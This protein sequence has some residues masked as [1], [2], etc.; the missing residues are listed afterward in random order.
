ML[1][2]NAADNLTPQTIRPTRSI[3]WHL[4]VL[5]AASIVPA[6]VVSTLL[7]HGDYRR[8]EERIYREGIL[9]ARNLASTLDR[10]LTGVES[11]LK[12]LATS[13]DLA[14]DDLASFHRRARDALRFQIVDNYFMTDREGRQYINTL[15]PYGTSLPQSGAPAQ[16]RRVFDTRE[17]V[18]TDIFL[19]KVSHRPTIAMGVPV[20]R[21]G[22][23]A[24]S[25][26]I[27]LS[28]DRIAAIA[29]V[30]NVPNGWIAAILDSSGNIV[31]RSR[32]GSRYIGQPAVQ[33]LVEAISRNRE[34]TLDTISKEGV[35]LFTAFS[36]SAISTW[37]VA[38][39]APQAILN[40]ELYR[41]L[42]WAILG[43]ICAVGIGMFIAIRLANRI[44]ASV[45]GLMN[46]AL[47]LG[48]GKTV[49]V[50]ES[51]LSETAAL[52]RTILEASRML[53]QAQHMAH[54]DALTGLCNRVLFD[55][56][57]AQHLSLS[58]RNGRPFALLAIDLD[59]FKAVND[60]QGHAAGD[61][62]LKTASQRITQNLRAADVTARLGGD[63]FAVLLSETDMRGARIVGDNLLRVLS[64][65][66]AGIDVNV[67][68]SIGIAIFPQ[69][70]DTVDSLLRAADEALYEAKRSGKGQLVVHA[71]A[72]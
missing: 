32:D 24:Y 33:P 17:T 20:L 69:S 59:G 2:H 70:G 27:G 13:D 7:I 16:L 66:Y 38:V 68:A 25:L 50:P 29:G 12:V 52:G 58:K 6:V 26:N 55:S 60:T 3:R 51:Q 67:S 14:A 48:S 49:E 39:G 45:R 18:L 30:Q 35:P 47:A 37:T 40:A 21:D 28:P 36:R 11:G 23:V 15:L 44:S 34:G 43:T 54:H 61:L 64:A 5:V 71:A 41:S 62:V 19:G 53:A 9:F 8:G 31:A 4:L 1:N 22:K 57:G 10:E 65:A 46:P 56:F 42:A 72:A 63:E